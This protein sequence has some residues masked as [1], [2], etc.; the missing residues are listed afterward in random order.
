MTDLDQSYQTL[1]EI[2]FEQKL[3]AGQSA[4]QKS[5]RLSKKT[6]IAGLENPKSSSRLPGATGVPS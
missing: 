3:R 6:P 1:A 2:N 4:V 5:K